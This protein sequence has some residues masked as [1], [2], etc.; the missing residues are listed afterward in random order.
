MLGACLT[1]IS[2]SWPVTSF[3]PDRE[4]C[5]AQGAVLWLFY[6]QAAANLPSRQ[7]TDAGWFPNSHPQHLQHEFA[8]LGTAFHTSP[9]VAYLHSYRLI[10]ITFD[11]SY[12]R[13]KNKQTRHLVR[14]H[15]DDRDKNQGDIW[16]D[17]STE[18]MEGSRSSRK[19]CPELTNPNPTPPTWELD[20]RGPRTKAVETSLLSAE[21]QTKGN[22]D[23]VWVRP[24]KEERGKLP[25]LS[26]Q[27]QQKHFLRVF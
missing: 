7:H 5:R 12:T 6:S 27:G 24:T 2:S 1:C 10:F 11:K 25:A 19:P 15:T 14:S 17:P 18:A 3:L 20:L 8:S 21:K 13:I 9:K 26:S 4:P 22:K 16:G 23:E